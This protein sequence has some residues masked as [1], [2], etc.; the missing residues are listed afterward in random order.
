MILLN[1][2]HPL[3]PEQ[4]AAIE[5]LTGQK[6]ERVIPLPVHFANDQPFLPQLQRLLSRIPLEPEELQTREFLI[7]PPAHNII[8]LL[9]LA[10]LH[11]QMGYFPSVVRLAPIEGATP[12]RF[13]VAEVINLQSVRDN[14][15]GKRY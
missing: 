9:L 13:Q 7:N 5:A 12:P 11:G 2:S 8:A 3:T 10:E 4:L 14:A 15:R 6:V 1:F